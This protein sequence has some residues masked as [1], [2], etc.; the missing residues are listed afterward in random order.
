[1]ITPIYR[2]TRKAKHWVRSWPKV[3]KTED[4]ILSLEPIPSL[5]SDTR[6]AEGW[7]RIVLIQGGEEASH[8]VGSIRAEF[9]RATTGLLVLRSPTVGIGCMNGWLALHHAR[10]SVDAMWVA[11]PP[12]PA[13]CASDPLAVPQPVPEYATTRQGGFLFE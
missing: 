13:A 9:Y 10:N 4:D 2:A 7:G 1:M 5:H 12:R 6:D 8:W 3:I 11:Q